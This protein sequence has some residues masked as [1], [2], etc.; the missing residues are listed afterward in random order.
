MWVT[1][2][3]TTKILIKNP[4]LLAPLSWCLAARPRTSGWGFQPRGQGNGWE[5]EGGSATGSDSEL[6]GCVWDLTRLKCLGPLLTRPLSTGLLRLLWGRWDYI[7][8]R[9][10]RG[11]HRHIR[12]WVSGLGEKGG[13]SE[14]FHHLHPFVILEFGRG[15]HCSC[16]RARNHGEVFIFPTFRA[17]GV[18]VHVHVHRIRDCLAFGV[19]SRRQINNACR[20]GGENVEGVFGR[21]AYGPCVGDK[22]QPVVDLNLP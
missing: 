19:G 13:K 5:A 16:D 20:A 2:D 10:G 6:W 17:L 22:P 11:G 8:G 15:G 18:D 4:P 9:M 3:D 21:T 12:R 1:R 14:V 7:D